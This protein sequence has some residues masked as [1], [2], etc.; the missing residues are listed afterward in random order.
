[1]H[2]RPIVVAASATFVL[3]AAVLATVLRGS[4]LATVDGVTTDSGA[5][6]A[7]IG[8][9]MAAVLPAFIRRIEIDTPRWLPAVIG[10]ISLSITLALWGLV[11]SGQN[12]LGWAAYG[13]FHVLRGRIGFADL[14]WI[15]QWIS[16]DQ[17]KQWDPNYGPSLT[18]LDSLAG[19]V[20]RPTFVPVFG[21]LFA[22]LMVLALVFLARLSQGRGVLALMVA[23]VGP[24]WLLQQDRANLDGLVFLAIVAGAWFV[25][26]HDRMYA[27]S[28]FAAVLFALGTLKYYPFIAVVALLPVLRLRRGLAVIGTYAVSTM[29]FM[30]VNWTDFLQSIAGN[31]QST[32]PTS[33]FPAYGRTMVVARM[34]QFA[35]ERLLSFGN[36]LFF[37]LSATAVAWGWHWSRLLRTRS[38]MLPTL[39][40]GGTTVFLSAVLIGGFGFMYKG[41]FLLLAVPML[42]LPLRTRSS[43]SRWVLYTS[44]FS[45]VLLVYAM[46]FAYASVLTTLAGIVAASIGLGAGLGVTWRLL[47]P[48]LA[49][50]LHPR[51]STRASQ[52][53]IAA[54]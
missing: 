15:A 46:T 43:D 8:L 3:L 6:I 35:D 37:G 23:A 45:L 26:R 29:A 49:E 20:L 51:E 27:W 16:C 42:A 34:G 39:S 52:A 5:R 28:A 47:R 50:Q 54:S 4:Q 12:A 10:A 48:V 9:L 7:F 33:E 21:V 2:T 31:G 1:M 24:A 14:D 17:C 36:L 44:V 41:V 40:L 32:D 22:S 19:Q 18:V 53:S 38:V 25:T 30:L 11:A 13:G